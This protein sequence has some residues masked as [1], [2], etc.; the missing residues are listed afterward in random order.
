MPAAP[1]MAALQQQIQTLQQAVTQANNAALYTH[2]PR[3]PARRSDS[4]PKPPRGNP[5]FFGVP[6][7]EGQKT[8]S[9][10][11][12]DPHSNTVK[13]FFWCDPHCQLWTY[14]S[15][16]S[17]LPCFKDK[18]TRKPA[19]KAGNSRVSSSNS[20]RRSR[21]NNR[22]QSHSRSDNRR[23]NNHSNDCSASRTQR[24]FSNYSSA[25]AQAILANPKLMAPIAAQVS[26][27]QR[28]MLSCHC[29]C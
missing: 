24:N 23:L 29:W 15:H 25:D 11:W 12:T 21:S 7:T 4:C 8:Q 20:D 14:T 18:P 16:S 17:D 27:A 22:R 6:P 13:T 19:G 28:L 26:E 9:Q 10:T 2:G 3:P 5:P 1:T